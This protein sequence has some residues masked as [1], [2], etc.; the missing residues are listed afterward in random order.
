MNV[1]SKKSR[2]VAVTLMLPVK[3]GNRALL[4]LENGQTLR[5]SI[6]EAII[7]QQPE[8]II[9]ETKNSIYHVAIPALQEGQAI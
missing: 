9:F 3:V 8:K 1:I 7:E 6:V 4:L 5:T 2:H